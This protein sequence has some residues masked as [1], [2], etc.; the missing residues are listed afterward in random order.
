MQN[1]ALL[2]LQ[3]ALFEHL[4]IHGTAV[5]MRKT[6]ISSLLQELWRSLKSLCAWGC[7]LSS[8]VSKNV[9]IPSVKGNVTSVNL[10][11]FQTF[12]LW[13]CLEMNLHHT[14]S[15]TTWSWREGSELS[16]KARA[17]FYP[18]SS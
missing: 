1:E 9:L 5:F 8:W 3:N 4:A 16:C 11:D 12:S 15:E 7:L 13:F 10:T 18:F 6:Y 14:R 17:L 2:T